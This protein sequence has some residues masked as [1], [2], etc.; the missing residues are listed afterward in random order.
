[1]F[2]ENDSALTVKRARLL[3][4]SILALGCLSQ[5]SSAQA[6]TSAPPS[7]LTDSTY[8]VLDFWVGTWNVFDSSNTKVG[9]SRIEKIVGGCAI[10]ENWTE[11]DGSEGKSLFYY[12][13]DQ[14][15]WKQVWV[16]PNAMMPGGF[17]EKRLVAKLPG[18]GVRFQGEIVGQLSIVLD[19]TTLTP[20][21]GGK[22]RQV[23]EISRNG[24]TSWTTTFDALYVPVS[25]TK[26]N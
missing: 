20:V 11:L 15:R 17:K 3:L 7:C 23:I 16:T 13:T 1:M 18:G 22:V 19:R 21:E 25:A 10:I 6:I 4:V 26:T 14:K 24:G 12:A 2:V 8:H 9:S 5:I